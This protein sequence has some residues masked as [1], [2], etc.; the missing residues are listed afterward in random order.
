[1]ANIKKVADG[2]AAVVLQTWDSLLEAAKVCSGR[3]HGKQ[4]G[5]SFV[6]SISKTWERLTAAVIESF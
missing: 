1:M 4:E 6:A 3:G 5:P 2:G